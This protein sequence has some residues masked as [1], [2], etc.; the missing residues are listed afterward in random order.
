MKKVLSTFS[1]EL[2]YVNMSVFKN[3][4]IFIYCHFNYFVCM[5]SW[6]NRFVLWEAS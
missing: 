2:N 4:S 5:V 1:G 6:I 3:I